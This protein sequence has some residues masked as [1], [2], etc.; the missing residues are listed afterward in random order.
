MFCVKLN[1]ELSNA[2]FTFVLPQF[3]ACA[4]LYHEVYPT[5]S[6]TDRR[7]TPL[8]ETLPE[9]LDQGFSSDPAKQLQWA[10]FLKKTNPRETPALSAAIDEIRAFIIPVGESIIDKKPYHL[11]WRPG[12]GWHVV[13]R[14][15]V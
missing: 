3:S 1:Y 2:R 15:E 11:V 4:P 6:H 10:S 8:P 13:K 14:K 5:E 9:G 7:K 12:H